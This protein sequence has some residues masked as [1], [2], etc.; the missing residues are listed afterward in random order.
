MPLEDLSVNVRSVTWKKRGPK[1]KAFNDRIGKIRAMPIQRPERTYSR[2]RKIEVLLFLNHH[3]VRDTSPCY[4]GNV[5]YRTPRI[6]E[7]VA[8]WKIP[9]QTIRDWVKNEDRI[10]AGQRRSYQSHYPEM[11]EQL[12]DCFVE[13]R[14]IGRLVS[15]GWL[16]R[17]SKQIF[18]KLYPESTSV[19]TF[20][21][22]WLRGFLSRYNISRRRLTKQA[23]KLPQE[24]VHFVSSFLRFIK[25]NSQP[26]NFGYLDRV[27]VSPRR[28]FPLS[29]IVNID[30]VPIPFEFLDGYTY[31][32][33]GSKTILGKSDRSGWGKRQATLILYIFADGVQRIKPKLI[34]HGDEASQR[35]ISKEGSQYS[36]GVT[37]EFN[38]T[39]YNNEVSFTRFIDE[40]LIPTFYTLDDDG[41][42]RQKEA[43]L[44]MDAATFHRTC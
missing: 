19:F 41:V 8:F 6:S 20:S 14:K 21:Q 30:E 11:E 39:A 12:Y 24:Y 38:K 4:G 34:F 22:G 31:D 3:M 44:V 36:P 13:R 18:E 10:L 9:H 37:V 2:R 1:P 26:I 29:R 28:R 35:I 7:A 25:R 32:I 16:R 5:V 40:E 15:A 27:L 42:R 33:C 43:L 17:Q 23:S